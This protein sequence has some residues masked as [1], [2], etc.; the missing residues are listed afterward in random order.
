MSTNIILPMILECMQWEISYHGLGKFLKNGLQK[1]VEILYN[2]L[3]CMCSSRKK[4]NLQWHL[5][6][7]Q[8]KKSPPSYIH[9]PSPQLKT[10][11]YFGITIFEFKTVSKEMLCPL[12]RALLWYQIVCAI[13]ILTAPQ[14]PYATT[15]L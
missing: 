7:L 3:Y 15:K 10:M 6:W 5:N 8:K 14:P 13:V 2:L 12:V 11:D 9:Y 1:T 4:E